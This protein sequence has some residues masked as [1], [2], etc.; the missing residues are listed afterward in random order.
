[1]KLNELT[2]KSPEELRS[3]VQELTEKIAKERFAL[4]SGGTKKTHVIATLKK[5]LA[6]T[7]TLLQKNNS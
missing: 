6:Q 1:M 2:T 3:H 7:K 5:E 4:R